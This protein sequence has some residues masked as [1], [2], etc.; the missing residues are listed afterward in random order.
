MI[1][2]FLNKVAWFVL[3]AM[4]EGMLL[5]S[6]MAAKTTLSRSQCRGRVAF[7]TGVRQ[8]NHSDAQGG[9]QKSMRLLKS[10]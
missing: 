7:G 9:Q 3:G 5:R 8:V 6:N 4:L 2:W 10:G 1:L